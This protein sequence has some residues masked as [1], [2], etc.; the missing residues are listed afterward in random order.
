MNVAKGR[1]FSKYLSPV[2]LQ[3][4]IVVAFRVYLLVCRGLCCNEINPIFS[5]QTVINE[6]EELP[7]FLL[8][9][10]HLE[11]AYVQPR[12]LLINR[13]YTFLNKHV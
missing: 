12:R 10:C 2:S 3:G 1:K 7:F 13:L 9:D 8:L 4:K 11:N 5:T 6:G